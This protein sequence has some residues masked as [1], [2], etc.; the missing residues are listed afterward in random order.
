[1]RA[2]TSWPAVYGPSCSAYTAHYV[3]SRWVNG[4]VG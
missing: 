4:F 3:V 2:E 1:M